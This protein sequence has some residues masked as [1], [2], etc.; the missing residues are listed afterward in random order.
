MT[1]LAVPPPSIIVATTHPA[2]PATSLPRQRSTT[3]HTVMSSARGQ[4]IDAPAPTG[5]LLRP[6]DHLLGDDPDPGTSGIA[7]VSG[8]AG[9]QPPAGSRPLRVSDPVTV[10]GHRLISR[11]GSGGMA[12]VF[13]ALTPTGRPVAV[14]LL[15][16]A[17]GVAE[18]CQR[19]HQLASSVDG[20]CTAPALAHGMSMAGAYLVTAHLPGY[21]C[22]STLV[23][24]PTPVSRLW[25]LAA[26]LARTLAAIHARSVVHCDVKPSNLLVRDHDVRIIDFGIARYVGQRCGDDGIVQCSRG[27]AAPEQ[28]RTAP[29]TPAVD[30]FAWGCL[31]AHLAAG[32]H[33]F[34]SRSEQ[35]WILRV[36]SAQPDLYGLPPHLH[37]LVRWALAHNPRHRPSTAELATICQTHDDRQPVPPPPTRT[38][39]CTTT[40]TP[41]TATPSTTVRSHVSVPD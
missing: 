9:A 40:P 34:A 13:Y 25:S 31:L 17:D 8:P 18:A 35:E 36:Q 19:E 20:R 29:A 22:G 1:T 16:P 12:D 7:A 28:L 10:D 33:P 23:G 37:D 14:K 27:W 11:L 26:A 21:Q 5:R 2:E 38:S 3:V 15:R 24:R 30:V 39:A 6:R 4:P 41:N 32:V